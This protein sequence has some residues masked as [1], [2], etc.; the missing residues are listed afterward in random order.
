[1]DVYYWNL[2]CKSGH[3]FYLTHIS[4]NGQ[5]L[6]KT[7]IDKNVKYKGLQRIISLYYYNTI[8]EVNKLT[9]VISLTY[10]TLMDNNNEKKIYVFGENHYPNNNCSIVSKNSRA[11]FDFIKM[12][13]ENIP[14]FMDLFIETTYLDKG[15]KYYNK[16]DNNITTLI[17]FET[18]YHNCLYSNNL[19]NCQ[20]PNV[21]IH[22]TDI[23]RSY[24]I[25]RPFIP[26]ILD[27][28]YR[29]EKA[30]RD[31]NIE[32]YKNQLKLYKE[33]IENKEN[34]H[35][36]NNY[37]LKSSSNNIDQL[38]LL[39]QSFYPYLKILKQ[40]QT[41]SQNVKDVLN[42]Y[43]KEEFASINLKYLDFTFIDKIISKLPKD[44]LPIFGQNTMLSEITSSNLKFESVFMDIYLMARVF[45]KFEQK[46]YQNSNQPENIIIYVGDVHAKNYRKILNRLKFKL[47]FKSFSKKDEFC[48]DIKN[49][50]QP[51][52]I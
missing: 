25:K 43:M 40:Q 41:L 35:N 9:N 12:N 39:F 49:L 4:E 15:G 26:Y 6:I 17:N 27:I 18:E 2:F 38:I 7:F 21:R 47:E 20:I 37:K 5:N 44:I 11:V 45:R 33:L 42:N 28:V 8:F 34:E 13:I 24:Q 36:V 29:I 46:N 52:F 10:H 30:V 51:L 31:K 23:R 22:N 32:M 3:I 1:M 16:N 19:K 14:K 50:K 48:I